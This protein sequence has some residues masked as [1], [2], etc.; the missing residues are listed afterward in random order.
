MEEKLTFRIKAGNFLGSKATQW[1]VLTGFVV[2]TVWLNSLAYFLGLA[3]ILLLLWSK[4][5][6][7]SLIGLKK[8]KNWIK[9]WLHAL[10]LAILIIIVVD[11]LLTPVIEL[12]LGAQPDISS[13]D[14]IRGNFLSY[15]IF[16]LFM[17]VVAAFGEEFVYRGLLVK[18]L[19][20]L[21]GNK[22]VTY[23]FAVLFSSILFGLA[24]QYQGL[25]GVI[26]TGIVGFLF[27]AIYMK[28]KNRLWL[29][30]LLHGIYDTILITLIYLD[31]DNEIFNL[32]GI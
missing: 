6:K 15:L 28:S 31:I 11:I 32:L 17:W 30:I 23:W 2:L 8:P 13:L 25:S 1:V 21:L 16:I 10:S 14:R 7:W 29:T 5:W 24:H 22:N 20:E 4:G 18:L 19:G 12:T 27:G 3:Y 9:V 26:C